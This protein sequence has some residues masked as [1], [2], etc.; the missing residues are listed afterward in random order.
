MSI[1]FD[2]LHEVVFISRL[3]RD[4][5]F[6]SEIFKNIVRFGRALKLT[7]PTDEVGLAFEFA[8][9]FDFV[10]VWVWSGV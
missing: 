1:G 6:A 7:F 5:F 2:G 4:D 8:V 10:W 9:V 3:W